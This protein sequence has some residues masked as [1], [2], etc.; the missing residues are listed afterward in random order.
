MRSKF[1]ALNVLVILA[2]AGLA[3][4]AS[5]SP[6]QAQKK[7]IT[8]TMEVNTDNS[9]LGIEMED[10]T[11]DSLAAYKLASERGVI[12]KRVEK[13]SPA[14]TA[15]LQEKDVIWEYAGTPVISAVQL[16]RMVRETPVGR[17]VDLVVSRDGKKLNLAAKIGKRETE[18]NAEEGHI[19][20]MPGGAGGDFEYRMPAPRA[21]S[22]RMPEGGMH[23]FESPDR[24]VFMYS[25]DRPRLGVTL[26]PVT[27]Q[28][29][30]F[31]GVP[32]KKGALVSSVTAGSAAAGKLKAGDVITKAGQSAISGPED[33]IRAVSKVEKGGKIDLAIVRDKKPMT[34]AIELPKEDSKENKGGFRL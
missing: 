20:F 21:F 26:Q 15:G 6:A 29:A 28:M 33:L 12:V 1:F 34:I 2:A 30:D 24:N 7:V 13:G 10:V 11:P 9:F 8:R 32:E 22:F 14:E 25:N 23:S 18:G 3:L 17:K 4:W 19:E 5:E 16:G 27:D 31:L